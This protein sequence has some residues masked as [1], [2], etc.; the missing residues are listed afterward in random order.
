MSEVRLKVMLVARPSK[1][2]PSARSYHAPALEPVHLVALA[3]GRYGMEKVLV[4]DR[5]RAPGTTAGS[6]GAACPGRRRAGHPVTS[7]VTDQ[8]RCV[9]P[10][11]QASVEV[12]A[13]C[14]AE[15]AP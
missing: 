9:E 12:S 3:D 5:M 10:S 4:T 14:P 13:S 2:E 15:I 1:Q 6:A 7:T 8:V 11:G